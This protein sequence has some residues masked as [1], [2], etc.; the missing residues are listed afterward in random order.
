VAILS[1]FPPKCCRRSSRTS[2]MLHALPISSDCLDHSN[3]IWSEHVIRLIILQLSS[4]FL[5]GSAGSLSWNILTLLYPI[6]L[7][8]I[9]LFTPERKIAVLYAPVIALFVTR[10]EDKDSEL[11]G[12]ISLGLNFLINRNLKWAEP[13]AAASVVSVRCLTGRRNFSLLHSVYACT[14]SHRNQDWWTYI[15]TPHAYSRCSA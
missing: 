8:F 4:A 14:G 1:R 5:P 13:R 10:G 3:Y 6:S 12:N 15:F 9:Y 2:G 7:Y 11:N